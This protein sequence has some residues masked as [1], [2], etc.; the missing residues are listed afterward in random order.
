ML[1]LTNKFPWHENLG[2]DIKQKLCGVYSL[3]HAEYISYELGGGR[4]QQ[5][6][7]PTQQPTQQTIQRKQQRTMLQWQMIQKSLSN[8]NSSSTDLT[9][10]NNSNANEL[11]NNN[12]TTSLNNVPFNMSNLSNN[13]T[14]SSST[15]SS[16]QSTDKS[17]SSHPIDPRSSD[18]DLSIFQLMSGFKVIMCFVMV[19]FL[20]TKI[21]LILMMKE[22]HKR[23]VKVNLNYDVM[24][25]NV[26][27]LRYYDGNNNLLLRII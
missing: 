7:Q 24:F 15:N 12:D 23:S 8:M 10:N 3:L 11:I 26:D 19:S 14:T 2:D 6:Q 5:T 17:N 21:V 9:R 16:F 1:P 20:I 18:T 4:E 13:P 22:R 27:V 25:K